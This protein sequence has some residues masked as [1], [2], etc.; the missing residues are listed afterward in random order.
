MLLKQQIHS[1]FEA[2]SINFHKSYFFV[3][4][5][6]LIQCNVMNIFADTVNWKNSIRRT[7]KYMRTHRDVSNFMAI[8]TF[9]FS[10]TLL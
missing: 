4:I 1:S 5:F 10:K 2:G 8:L 7:S 3:W 9:F 6:L